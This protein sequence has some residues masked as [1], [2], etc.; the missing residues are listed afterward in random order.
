MPEFKK[1]I[2]LY[3]RLINLFFLPISQ[4]IKIL[5]LFK[6]PKIP[7]EHPINKKYAQ[8]EIIQKRRKKTP[9]FT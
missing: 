5:K 1:M 3:D 8:K 2:Q 9:I 4:K 7:K 6:N